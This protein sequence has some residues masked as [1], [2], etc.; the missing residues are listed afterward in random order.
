M[1]IRLRIGYFLFG[2]FLGMVS[3]FFQVKPV[4]AFNFT[5]PN[6]P[7]ISDILQSIKIPQIPDPRILPINLPNLRLLPINIPIRPIKNPIDSIILTPTATPSAT[8][9]STITPIPTNTPIPTP[10]FTPSPT[11]TV[12]NT[13]TPTLTP[14]PTETPTPT[15]SET[16]IPTFTLTPTPTSSGTNG[17]V[18][19]W[20]ME[21]G[22]GGTLLD[23]SGNNHSLTIEGTPNWS[24]NLP[25]TSVSDTQT[26]LFDG[27]T[28]A[29]LTN[30]G[31]NSAFD[32]TTGLTLEAWI[33]TNSTNDPGVVSK[34]TNGNG[35]MLFMTGGANGRIEN[36]FAG[37]AQVSGGTKVNDGNWHHVAITWDG[38]QRAVY[39]DGILDATPLLWNTSPTNSGTTFLLGSYNNGGEGR[40]VGNI[41]EV[42]VWNYARSASEIIADAGIIQ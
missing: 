15:P 4:E 2:A 21:E 14:I 17:L 9:T 42:K 13:P 22:N 39:I 23:S 27:S 19:Y 6:V 34:W 24:S 1:K 7:S 18:A 20:K 3:L 33:K 41:D 8:P 31:D 29:R 5:L 36:N 38:S 16:P 37:G 30:S 12:T 40:L 10:T 11:P 28:F 25:P 26:F 32:F 35:Y